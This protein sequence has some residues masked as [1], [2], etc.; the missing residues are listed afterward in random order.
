MSVLIICYTLNS[1]S[2]YIDGLMNLDV[3]KLAH[4]AYSCVFKLYFND[5]A[6]GGKNYYIRQREGGGS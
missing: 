1:Q 5:A 2:N 3:V 4:M 6:N